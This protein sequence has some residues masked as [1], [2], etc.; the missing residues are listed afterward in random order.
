[1]RRLALFDVAGTLVR[2]RGGVGAQYAAVAR[3]V[4][5]AADPAALAP[6]FPAAFRAAPP[7]A[8]PGVAPADV[9]ARERAVW[10]AIVRR[11][12]GEAGC[13]DGVSD[14]RF[15]ELFAALWDHFATAA[16]WEVYPDAVPALAAL[17]DRGVR[18]GVVTN[19]DS[20]VEPLLAALGLAGWFQSLTRSSAAGAAK[21]DPAIFRAAL[22]RHG[23]S[24]AEALHV[25]DSP[26]EDVAGAEAAG[27]LGVLVDRAGRHAGP[28]R[29]VRVAAL[30]E[31]V[32][33][34]ESGLD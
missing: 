34:L 7:M 13:L 32:G 20:R 25:G 33:L 15:A 28:P 21:P 24:P 9:P 11:V 30:T 5:I 3:G 14:A 19:F 10:M 17:R 23:A 16:A 18:L 26:G 6:G 8:F 12:F 2:V 31:V 1:M 22:A 29:G 27:L 4:G